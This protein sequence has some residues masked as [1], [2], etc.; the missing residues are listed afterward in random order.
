MP[1]S[2]WGKKH[3]KNNPTNL[4]PTTAG[5]KQLCTV[6]SDLSG[7]KDSELELKKQK[8]R[9]RA[10]FSRSHRWYSCTYEVRALVGAADLTFELWFN[11]QRFSA[12]HEP[13]KVTWDEEGA[14]L[15]G[16]QGES[17]GGGG[18]SRGVV[19]PGPMAAAYRGADSGSA[20][21]SSPVS[22]VSG[23]RSSDLVSQAR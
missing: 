8:K 15:G 21:G 9:P 4:T 22:G 14:G 17:V 18:A 19:V 20:S 5:A 12:N 16:G 2:R 13:I 3:G 23:L 1:K 10:L 11:G 6:R 7:V